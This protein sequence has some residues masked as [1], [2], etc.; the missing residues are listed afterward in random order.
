MYESLCC[1]QDI[2]FFY[3]MCCFPDNFL[4]FL[5][6][7]LTQE[8]E[9]TQEVE[10]NS[11][12]VREHLYGHAERVKTRNLTCKNFDSHLRIKDMAL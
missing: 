2:F 9:I 11:R 5:L 4:F 10:V 12:Y 8:V 7:V 6:S 1:F 3:T